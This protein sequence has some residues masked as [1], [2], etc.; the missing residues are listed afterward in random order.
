ELLGL[1]TAFELKQIQKCRHKRRH[2]S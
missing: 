2:Y 1:N